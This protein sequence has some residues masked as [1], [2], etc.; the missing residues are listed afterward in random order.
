MSQW[1]VR[2]GPVTDCREGGLVTVISTGG[3]G[4]GRPERTPVRI[5]RSRVL[6]GTIS[7]AGSTLERVYCRDGVVSVV[8]PAGGRTAL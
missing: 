5:A 2:Y 4:V 7:Q 3:R 8:S 6:L 1:L